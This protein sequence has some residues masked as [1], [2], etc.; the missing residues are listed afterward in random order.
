MRLIG[1]KVHPFTYIF[2]F[3]Y[4]HHEALE[5]LKEQELNDAHIAKVEEAKKYVSVGTVA[6]PAEGSHGYRK[7]IEPEDVLPGYMLKL[8]DGYEYRTFWFELFETCV[9]RN[10]ITC[11]RA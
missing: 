5:A 1:K 3:F 8:T 4:K 11:A 10:F 2:L 7:R 6:L 9:N